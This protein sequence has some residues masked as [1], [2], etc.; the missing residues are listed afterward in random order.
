MVRKDDLVLDSI[1]CVNE[2]IQQENLQQNNF[3]K[4]YCSNKE[5][6]REEIDKVLDAIYALFV[7]IKLVKIWKQH[8]KYLKFM[9]VVPNKMKKNDGVFFV[10]YMSL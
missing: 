5:Y 4:S 8:H 10:S 3:P 9:G 2:D 1:V 7:T 6:G